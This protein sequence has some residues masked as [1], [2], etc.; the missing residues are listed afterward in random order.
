[1]FDIIVNENISNW[2]KID[3][4]IIYTLSLNLEKQGSSNIRENIF[5]V[6]EEPLRKKISNTHDIM[7]DNVKNQTSNSEKSTNRDYHKIISDT[8]TLNNEFNNILSDL[9]LIINKV[10]VDYIPSIHGYFC[11][12]GKE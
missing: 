12:Y 11:W 9:T 4:L 7:L 6:V 1:M 10:V 2:K 3:S 8:L 5:T